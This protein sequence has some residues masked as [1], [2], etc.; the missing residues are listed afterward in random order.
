[1]ATIF[2]MKGSCGLG[3]FKGA[4]KVERAGLKVDFKA[5]NEFEG[6]GMHDR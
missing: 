6:K 4:I 2:G 5:K 1:M 3:F